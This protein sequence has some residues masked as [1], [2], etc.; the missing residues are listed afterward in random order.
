MA[1]TLIDHT[2]DVGI[3]VDAPS[4]EAM[5]AEAAAALFSILAG[6]PPDPGGSEEVLALPEGD[7][8]EGLRDFLGE[9]L[10]RFSEGRRMYVAF[11]PLCGA[12]EARWEPYDPVRHP[13]RTELK[14]VTWHQL[15]AGESGGR[16]KARVIFDV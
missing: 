9:L 10:Y 13:L 3:D 14:A 6:T 8:A 2:G 5:F 11:E 4:K 7:V 15:A 1:W 12:V 16:W